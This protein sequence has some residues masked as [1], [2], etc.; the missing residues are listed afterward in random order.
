[1][2]NIDFLK[3]ALAEE[4][5][6]RTNQFTWFATAVGIAARYE[7]ESKGISKEIFQ[8]AIN[9]GREIG[10]DLSREE[11]ESYLIFNKNVLLF[12]S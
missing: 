9:E 11:K 6:G 7:K 5:I 12:Y 8:Q 2:A 3:D 1:M 10:L 4:Q